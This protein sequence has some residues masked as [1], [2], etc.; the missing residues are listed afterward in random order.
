MASFVAAYLS[1]THFENRENCCSL[2][3]LPSD[4]ARGSE[5]VKRA[6]RQVFEHMVGNL[7]KG[8]SGADTRIRARGA[9]R[10]GHGR[11]PRRGRYEVCQ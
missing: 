6:Y 5:P 8:L 9:L 3:A 4:V 7:E 1:Q 11:R 2:M 10:R